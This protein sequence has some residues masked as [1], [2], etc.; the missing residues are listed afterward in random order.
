M[1]RSWGFEVLCVVPS[2]TCFLELG[3]FSDANLLEGGDGVFPI[4]N[5]VMMVVLQLQNT[6]E[7]NGLSKHI[8]VM[9]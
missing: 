3:P 1:Y 9:F 5:L 7:G 6:F 8:S 4:S 2:A